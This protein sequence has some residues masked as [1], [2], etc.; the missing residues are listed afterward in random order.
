MVARVFTCK[1]TFSWYFFSGDQS[2]QSHQFCHA[3]LVQASHGVSVATER[4]RCT[5]PSSLPLE[6]H[7][8][9][10][11]GMLQAGHLRLT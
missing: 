10:F 1:V 11:L 2:F 8:D 7:T 5:W 6:E 4:N 9:D 3:D